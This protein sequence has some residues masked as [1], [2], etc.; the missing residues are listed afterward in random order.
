M[1]N[2]ATREYDSQIDE[3]VKDELEIANIPYIVLPGYM[4]TEVKTKYIGMMNGF[5]FYRAWTY[6]ICVGDM[7]L[8]DA[9]FI[10]ENY[11][12]LNIRAGGHCGNVHPE[13]QSYNPIYDAELRKLI[14]SVGIKEYT[15][16]SKE[17]VDDK[18]LPRFVSIYHIDTQ[19]GLCRLAQTIR[20]RDIQTEIKNS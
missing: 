17:I 18:T 19:L 2:F 5:Q 15:E 4:T 7:P 6:W 11:K 1:E 9:E 14:R 13:T 8:H 16:K 10:Y 20:D 3:K 12:N